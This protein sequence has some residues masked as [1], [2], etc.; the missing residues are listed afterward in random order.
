MAR[1]SKLAFAFGPELN[2][3]LR[4]LRKRRARPCTTVTAPRQ[5]DSGQRPVVPV[6]I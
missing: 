3:R 1:N 4:R 2:A 6:R 5:G